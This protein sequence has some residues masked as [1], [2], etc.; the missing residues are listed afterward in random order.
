VK[1][2][3]F[4]HFI[5]LK[6]RQYACICIY[7]GNC[8]GKALGTYSILGFC[9]TGKGIKYIP[10]FKLKRRKSIAHEERAPSE[11]TNKPASELVRID[12]RMAERE[13]RETRETSERERENLSYI[14]GTWYC[15]THIYTLNVNTNRRQTMR[16]KTQVM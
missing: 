14:H 15:C 7:N 6:T 4:S 10:W 3:F 12:L 13:E 1:I 11:R 8:S 2:S 5:S 16:T 9:F